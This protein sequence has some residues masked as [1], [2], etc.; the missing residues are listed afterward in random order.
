[1]ITIVLGLPRSG[2][3]LLMQMLE[4][5]GMKIYT[6][7]IRKADENNSNGYYEHE[8]V[9]QLQRD[10][11]WFAEVEGKAIKVIAQLIEY[12]PPDF[13]YQALFIERDMDE[14]ITSQR[15]MLERLG[16]PS[17]VERQILKKTFQLQ[18]QNIKQWLHTQQRIKIYFSSA[19]LMQAIYAMKPR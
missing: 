11:S 13:L 15:V 6:D 7:N 1:M 19:V 18:V 16:K 8:K 17:T 3:S 5:G 10:N 9:K 14:I 12:V 4:A 2:T